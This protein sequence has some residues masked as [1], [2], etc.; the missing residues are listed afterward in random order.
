MTKPLDLPPRCYLKHGAFFYVTPAGKWVNLGRDRDKALR[1]YAKLAVTT[2]AL[3][4]S[5]MTGLIDTA[6]PAICH[7]KAKSTAKLYRQAAARLRAIFAEF[8][9]DDVK[10]K[11][12]AQVKVS[13][14]DTPNLANR[15]LTVLRLLFTYAVEQQ[16][17]EWNPASGI[18]P[19]PEA[20]RTRLLADAEIDQVLSH[21]PPRLKALV[22]LLRVTGQRVSDVLALRRSDLT[23][24]GVV[25]VQGKTGAR[26]TLRWTPD[27]RAAVD[28][29]LALHGPVKRLTVFYGR[30][31]AGGPPGYATILKQW[32]RAVAASGVKDANLHDLRAVAVTNA[33]R[34]GTDAQAL[35]GHSSAAMTRRYIRDKLGVVVTPPTLSKKVSKSA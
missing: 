21:C 31:N 35:A 22:G 8:G 12:V 20:K 6:L 24:E 4:I 5:R 14:R 33:H 30:R 1:E 11:H 2:G 16:L 7:G 19:Y 17:C 26:V 23:D 3:D 13:M 27:L 29:A 28:A 18:K 25:F 34:Q 10:P 32:R 9:V 15:F